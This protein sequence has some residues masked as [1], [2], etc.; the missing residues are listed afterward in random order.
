[1]PNTFKV[2][3]VMTI[4][5]KKLQLSRDEH[6]GMI[7]L[8]DGKYLMKSDELLAKIYEKHHDKED[9]FLYIVYAQEQVYGG[10]TLEWGDFSHVG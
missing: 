4:V 2:S 3:E 5:R 7:L 1:M 9:G 8:A 6:L 10:S